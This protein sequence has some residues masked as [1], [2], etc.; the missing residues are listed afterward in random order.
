[1]CKLFIAN[2]V[3]TMRVE[4]VIK[5]ASVDFFKEVI[6]MFRGNVHLAGLVLLK[7][8]IFFFFIVPSMLR[9]ATTCDVFDHGWHGAHRLR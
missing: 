4:E 5:I 7:D 6:D 8:L 9:I 1:M 3:L 2:V